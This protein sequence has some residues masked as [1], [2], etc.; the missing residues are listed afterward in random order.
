MKALWSELLQIFEK[1]EV[2]ITLFSMMSCSS[3]S[4]NHWFQE[5][6]TRDQCCVN[7]Y[8]MQCAYAQSQ[9]WGEHW[10]SET[11]VGCWT[12]KMVSRTD[13]IKIGIGVGIGVLVIIIITS[14]AVALS[15]SGNEGMY[16]PE[17][18]LLTNTNTNTQ[19][20]YQ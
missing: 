10:T 12:S 11:V 14:I 15:S 16:I 20:Q 5:C 18:W 13:A 17:H 9:A 8:Y 2:M 6:K 4:L 19:Y 3:A 7:R 1:L